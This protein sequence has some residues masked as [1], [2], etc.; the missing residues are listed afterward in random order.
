MGIFEGS[1]EKRYARGSGGRIIIAF[2]YDEA[3]HE[4]IGP[5]L[6]PC[7]G[8]L[9]YYLRRVAAHLLMDAG[10]TGEAQTHQAL[11]TAVDSQSPHLVFGSG[12]LDGYNM[13]HASGSGHDA[14]LHT[15]FAKSIGA[16][17]LGNAQ[18]FPLSAVVYLGLVLGYL[19][20]NTSP[21]LLFIDH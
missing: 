18:L 7:L 20:A 17:E 21:V 8:S 5:S 1:Q 19:V 4:V 6:L 10:M 12:G 9:A 2:R 15:F 16:P 3:T 13:M 11:Q 14:L